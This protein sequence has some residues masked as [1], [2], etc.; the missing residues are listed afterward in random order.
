MSAVDEDEEL[1]DAG[2]AMVE[3]CVEGG[4]DGAA[5]VEDVVHEDDVAA[6]DVE[7]D[8]AGGDGRARAGGGEVVAVKA[9]V[10]YAG[11]DGVLF[12]GGDEGADA[13]GEGDSAALDADEAEIFSAVVLFD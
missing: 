1:D 3:E 6:G 4:A 11:V 10:E 9:D 12:D 7:A 5:G 8:G 2:A 13:L